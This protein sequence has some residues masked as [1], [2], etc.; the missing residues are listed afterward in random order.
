MMNKTVYIKTIFSY[1][2]YF[3]NAALS[4]RVS[5][6]LVIMSSLKLFFKIGLFLVSVKFSIV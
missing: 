5:L 3:K 6:V 1:T 2:K 4:F